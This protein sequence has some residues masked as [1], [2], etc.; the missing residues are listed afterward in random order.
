MKGKANTVYQVF[1]GPN[2][3]FGRGAPA[4]VAT[5]TDGLSN[6]ILAVESSDAVPWTKP[7]GIPFDRNKNVPDFGKAYGKK[8]LALM[9]D[10]STRELDLNKICPYLLLEQLGAGGMGEVF[11]ARHR[12]LGKLVALKLIHP[13]RLGNPELAHRFLREVR[14]ASRLDHA[15]IVHAIDAGEADGRLYLAMEYVEGADLARLVKDHGALPP[16]AGAAAD[17]FSSPPSATVFFCFGLQQT[18]LPA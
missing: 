4:M 14:S 1:T 18:R 13:D 8:P 11:K 9:M 7:G 12:R 6:T 2:A 17:R 16:A 5:I 10:T 3:V 15:N